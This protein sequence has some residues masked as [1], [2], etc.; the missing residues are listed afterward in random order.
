MV[1]LIASDRKIFF[2]I[3]GHCHARK[4]AS[5]RETDSEGLV[6]RGGGGRSLFLGVDKIGTK[7]V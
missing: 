3:F 6:S 7:I 5:G 2:D 4:I 1:S